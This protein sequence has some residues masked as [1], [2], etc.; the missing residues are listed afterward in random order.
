MA[1][2]IS[3]VDTLLG[4]IVGAVI[5]FL[6]S[7]GL[8]WWKQNAEESELKNRIREELEIILNEAT[9]DYE[10]KTSQNREYRIEAFVALKIDLVRKLDAKT[11]RSIQDIYQK[12]DGLKDPS[13]R[14]DYN[15]KKYKETIE[16]IEETITL[17]KID[18][19]ALRLWR[20]LR[21]HH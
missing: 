21:S 17:L 20:N 3:M 10:K 12:I 9:V 4:V 13:A 16:A 7:I 1:S 8:E 15:K 6:G 18:S 14:I 2:N 11:F 5:G 19:R